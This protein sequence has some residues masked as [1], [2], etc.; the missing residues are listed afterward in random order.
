MQN[1]EENNMAVLGGHDPSSPL[2]SDSTGSVAAGS[3]S[4]SRTSLTG[5]GDA[6]NVSNVDMLSETSSS[7]ESGHSGDSEDVFIDSEGLI[8]DFSVEEVI[9]KYKSKINNKTTA[10]KP[11]ASQKRM[12]RRMRQM[13]KEEKQCLEWHRRYDKVYEPPTPKY[14]LLEDNGRRQ[15]TKEDIMRRT[16][17]MGRALDKSR[18]ELPEMRRVTIKEKQYIA[19]TA[20]VPNIAKKLLEMTVIGPCKVKITKDPRKN[21]SYGIVR[22]V[23][24]KMYGMSEAHI[25]QML[26]QYGAVKSE[27][28]T[29]WNNGRKVETASVKVTFDNPNCPMAVYVDRTRYDIK[30]FVPPPLRCFKCQRYDHN[31][32]KCRREE[33]TCQRCGE[34]GHQARTYTDGVVSST[35]GKTR[36]CVN[37][38]GAHEAGFRKC[39]VQEDYKKIN[40]IMVLQKISRQEAK[41]RVMPRGNG[42]TTAENVHV[43]QQERE[44]DAETRQRQREQEALA[45][46]QQRD[47]DASAR[48]QQR[49]QDALERQQQRAQEDEHRRIREER[50]NNNIERMEALAIRVEQML[51]KAGNTKTGEESAD[52]QIEALR[53]ECDK[54]F[55]NLEDRITEQNTI[56]ATLS[57]EN[58]KLREEKEREKSEKEKLQRELQKM[59][60]A[61]VEREKVMVEMQMKQMKEQENS[62]MEWHERENESKK[63]TSSDPKSNETKKVDT[64]ETTYSESQP[65]KPIWPTLP[66]IKN[67]LD[68]GQ[69][70]EGGGGDHG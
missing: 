44:Q 33:H 39:R 59:R 53:R 52:S 62:H 19:I 32:Y 58:D 18:D 30:E 17:W 46:Q 26:A 45:L 2:L 3:L 36:K 47:Q 4:T 35:C 15:Y 60:D 69:G 9:K 23:E 55:Q 70:R 13:D 67:S 66:A 49:D 43:R 64:K 29:T 8:E 65:N 12:E 57:A 27:R 21:L 34:T 1:K 20:E 50:E 11:N 10:E 25:T 63:R 48:Q 37:C 22:D 24:R 42:L 40:E 16:A 41:E 68:S 7:D 61:A 54:K 6:S 51:G 14:L 38:G 28:Q 56:I 31:V 5:Y